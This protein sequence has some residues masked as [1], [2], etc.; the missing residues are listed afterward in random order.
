MGNLVCGISSTAMNTKV[1]SWGKQK[2]ENTLKNPIMRIGFS[3]MIILS[4]KF[5]FGVQ[6]KIAHLDWIPIDFQYTY[7][8][9]KWNKTHKIPKPRR[10]MLS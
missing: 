8:E 6:V 7:K 5:L 3:A 1:V 4:K 2:W 9:M 10:L